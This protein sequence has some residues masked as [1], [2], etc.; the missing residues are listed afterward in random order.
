[1]TGKK[2]I[3]AELTPETWKKKIPKINENNTMLILM[4][5]FIMPDKWTRAQRWAQELSNK[6]AVKMTKQQEEK[7]IKN[8]AE[9]KTGSE[10]AALIL[11][12]RSLTVSLKEVFQI[13]NQNILSPAKAVWS[14]GRVLGGS[15]QINHKQ[16]GIQPKIIL[17]NMIVRSCLFKKL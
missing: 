15:Q 1:M 9:K 10:A 13:F 8:I 4:I 6:G 12:E 11:T 14:E 2:S 3:N 5:F 16:E 7:H 17:L